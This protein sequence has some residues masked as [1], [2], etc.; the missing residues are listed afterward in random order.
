MI[1]YGCLAGILLLGRNSLQAQSTYYSAGFFYDQDY[2]L[3]MIGLRSLNQ[4]RNYTMGLG[5]FTEFEDLKM[6]FPY[7]PLYFLNKVFKR[8]ILN[9]PDKNNPGVSNRLML[10]NGSFTPDYLSATYPIYNDRP[11]AS[12]TYLQLQSTFIDNNIYK[13]ISSNFNIGLLG[14]NISKTVQT[15]IHE[16]LNEGDTKDPHT[17]KGWHN[18]ISNGGE[19][20]FLYAGELEKLI[21]IRNIKSTTRTSLTAIEFKHGLR[22]S[23]GYYTLTGYNFSFRYGKIDPRNWA[24]QT[25]PLGYSTLLTD[26]YL[27]KTPVTEIYLY[28]SLRPTFI[29]YNALLNGQ[30]RDSKVT[31]S[32]ANTRHWVLDGEGGICISP[33]IRKKDIVTVRFRFAGRSP[34][35][36]F[37]SRPKRSHFWGGIDLVFMHL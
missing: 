2:T 13:K 29:L 37:P 26:D 11:Y 21:T 19:L 8:S 27:K 12:L 4:D 31:V 14:T 6:W 36:S 22:Y 1:T 28:G 25:N 35:I 9:D 15:K 23:L 17:P 24:Y 10:A 34:E 18:Q 30:F 33:V 32:F 7:R 3:E 5:F 16:A 20:T